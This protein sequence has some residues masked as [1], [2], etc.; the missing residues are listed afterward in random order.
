MHSPHS[1]APYDDATIKLIGTKRLV[2]PGDEMKVLVILPLN[3]H[4]SCNEKQN[5]F[6]I[7]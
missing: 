6:S 5:N 2:K 3:C 4:S 1:S 7:T